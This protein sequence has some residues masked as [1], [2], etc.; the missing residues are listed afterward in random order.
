MRADDSAMTVLGP[1]P[2]DDLGVTLTHE[3]ILSDLTCFHRPPG[4]DEEARF[5]EQPLDITM[6]GKVRRDPTLNRDNCV[7]AD[8]SLAV[9]ELKEF[10]DLGGQT[11]VD[12][13]LP[14]I[15][16]DATGLAQIARA[17]ELHIVC[18]CGHL[19]HFTQPPGVEVESEETVA[20][21]L[22]AELT[23][24]IADTGILPGIIGE[25]GV[26]D[27]PHP[28]EEKVLRAA[29]RAQKE[30]G[31]PLSVHTNLGT[32][33][34]HQALQILEE[35]DADMDRVV[36]GHLDFALGHPDVTFEQALEYH[37]SLAR[38]GCFIEYDTVGADTYFRATEQ[39]PAFW[40]P[41]DR[42]RA[43]AVV[44]LFEAGAGDQILLSQD[45][46][47]KHYLKRYGGYGYGHILREFQTNLRDAGLDREAVD[48]LLVANPRR[49]L[50]GAAD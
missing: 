11:I 33:N 42:E 38:S 36:L 4:S 14:D 2:A 35:A 13:S 12:V 31:R 17:T 44:R 32:R 46:C 29:V 10:R 26:S 6:L 1:V 39:E 21:R 25:I 34:G 15:G 5:A 41:S 40:C 24:G 7:L 37:L 47:L 50:T 27:P 9:E 49:M 30:T 28:L 45:I 16:R 19:L 48:R 23:E 43:A 8:L 22:V 20:E 3:H 18:G